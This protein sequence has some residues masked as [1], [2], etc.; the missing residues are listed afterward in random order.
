MKNENQSKGL[1]ANENFKQPIN[2]SA[3][4]K[5]MGIILGRGNRSRFSDLPS[6]PWESGS[7]NGYKQTASVCKYLYRFNLHGWST[8]KV[9]SRLR[10]LYL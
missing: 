9:S 2:N 6:I 10:S 8:V 1:G 3:F 4:C 7:S 5:R